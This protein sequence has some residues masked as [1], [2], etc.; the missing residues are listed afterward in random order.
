MVKIN[1]ISI[2]SIFLIITF[3]AI[4]LFSQTGL[5][6]GPD[7]IA[8]LPTS[9]PEWENLLREANESAGNPDLSDQDD[10]TNVT[11]MAKAL[12]YARTGESR[13]REEVIDA[14]MAA[15]ETENGGRTLALGRELIGY[16]IAA[17]LVGLPPDKDA[18]FREWLAE[19]RHE[20]LDGK[21]LISTHEDRPN[22]WG[23]HAGGSRV[24]VAVYLGDTAEI[25][26][27][28]QVFHGWLGDRSAYDGF[29]YGD[30]SWQADSDNP[31]GIN[32]V[33]A[34]KDGRNIDGV[35]PD[36]QRR[37]GSFDWPPPKEN[38]VYEALQGALAQAVILH[39]VGYDVWNWEDQA[40]R[41]AFVW[42]HDQADFEAGGDDSWEPH[43]INHFYDANF[44]ESTTSTPG[45]NVGWTEWTHG[46]IASGG[47]GSTAPAPPL[48]LRIEN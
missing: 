13:Y 1:S 38:Y 48:N 26:R 22:N 15:I 10:R 28:A 5:W 41:R 14:C 4:N 11:V 47:D 3:F 18:T 30:L 43:L 9:G 20:T 39:R 7:E 24:A 37:G 42:L 27:C 16:V 6:I 23:T 12:V 40:L 19:V 32:P 45:K 44:P 21:T 31:V 29:S 34:V 35:L 25:E 8:Q 33:G 36:D 17:D 46:L 2:K